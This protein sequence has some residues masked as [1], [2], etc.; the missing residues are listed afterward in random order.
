MPRK[1]FP[2]LKLGSGSLIPVLSLLHPELAHTNT[3]DVPGISGFP[4]A[5]TQPHQ[6]FKRTPRDH[7]KKSYCS[8]YFLSS[9][10]R[11]FIIIC[12][13][14]QVKK[15]NHAKPE[16]ELWVGSSGRRM[17]SSEMRSEW[18]GVWKLSSWDR[19]KLISCKHIK[20]HRDVQPQSRM[21]PLQ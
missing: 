10:V 1:R 14:Q 18:T 15:L 21:V 11:N 9:A 7:G 8:R 5:P 20:V 19:S 17:C 2:K 4:S 6:E 16:Q 12:R 3:Q 13:M